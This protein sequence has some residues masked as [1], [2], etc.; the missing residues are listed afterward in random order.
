MSVTINKPWLVVGD[1]NDIV[2]A[3]EKKGGGQVFA[4]K[5]NKFRE[6]IEDCSLSDLGCNGPKF[7][8]HEPIYHGGQSIFKRLDRAL[9]NEKWKLIF[10]NF[11]IRVLTRVEFSDHHPIMISLNGN[12]TERSPKPFRFESAWM[13]EYGYMDR[14]KGFWSNK[15]DL[16]HNLQR[17]VN[18]PTDWKKCSVQHVQRAKRGIVARLH[19][20]QSRI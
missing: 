11:Q 17:I 1:F 9:S 14:M 10:A 15:D 8:W 5:C 4:R 13:V 16:L 2:C 12:Y 3:N 7:T 19:G 18:D 6:N 20:I